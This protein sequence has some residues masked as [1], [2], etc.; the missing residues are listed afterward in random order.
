LEHAENLRECLLSQVIAIR[1]MMLPEEISMTPC[2][3]FV[4]PHNGRCELYDLA[5]GPSFDADREPGE[6]RR[7]LP[8]RVDYAEEAK[9][10]AE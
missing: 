9:E 5:D 1:R 2:T 10:A 6:L 7:S 8:A 4:L 3:V